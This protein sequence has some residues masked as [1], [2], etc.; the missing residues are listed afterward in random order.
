MKTAMGLYL[1]GN[2][3]TSTMSSR[4]GWHNFFDT[5]GS[6]LDCL[7]LLSSWF[8]VLEL[9][10]AVGKKKQPNTMYQKRISVVY[11]KMI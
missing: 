11:V 6:D 8:C 4:E 7:V 9:T 2:S 1:Q 10:A 5:N 3:R